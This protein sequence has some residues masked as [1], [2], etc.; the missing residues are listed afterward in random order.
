MKT[1][2]FIGLFLTFTIVLCSKV[3]I[4]HGQQNS[5]VIFFQYGGYGDNA[6]ATLD[7]YVFYS[8]KTKNQTDTLL[9]LKAVRI[10]AVD[11][12]GKIFKV[13]ITDKKGFFSIEFPFGT[14]TIKLFRENYQP[15]IVTN[16]ASRAD[17]ITSSEFV[18][19]KGLIKQYFR[20]PNWIN[21]YR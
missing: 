10:T 5:R 13:T 8:S 6:F 9:P 17:Q 1:L 12:T 3:F 4:S 11:S 16:Y 14:Y 2:K 20:V 21:N 19:E 15:L 18:L 7:G